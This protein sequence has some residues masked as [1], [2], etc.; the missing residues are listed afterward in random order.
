MLTLGTVINPVVLGCH[1]SYW[2][3]YACIE[4]QKKEACI[5]FDRK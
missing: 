2:I 1:E 3:C 5:K 4:L